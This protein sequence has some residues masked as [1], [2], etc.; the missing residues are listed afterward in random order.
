MLLVNKW[1]K[2]IQDWLEE[3]L[4]QGDATNALFA[5][6]SPIQGWIVAKSSGVV[7]GLPL[8]AQVFQEL[9][10]TTQLTF[11]KKDGQRIQFGEALVEL[12]GA[13]QT[14]LAGERLAL[15]L[16]QRLSGIATLTAEYV[17]QVRD[18]SVRIVDTRKTTP[19]LR[20]LE[21]YAV[22]MG[23]GHNHRLGLY[24]AAMIKD[25]HI[26]AAGGIKRAVELLRKE[27]PHTMKIEVEAES[28]E[29][30]QEALQVQADIIM[31]DNMSLEG[32]KEAV[33]LIDQR[34]IVEASGGVNLQTV[35]GIAE[36]GVDVI[37]VGA[38]THSV[39]SLDISMDIGQRK[40]L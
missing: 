39:Q 24:D 14:L 19:G 17:E 13:P 29:Q 11:H 1:R 22:R 32:M 12:K 5:E 16:L 36:T 28:I 8:V 2:Q 15:N 27:L 31:L 7:A 38:L 33:Q 26:K 40:I 30:V 20:G 34:A 25:N 23:G 6:A 37:S 4:G 9:D 18:T 10:P 3:D 21:K 35:R